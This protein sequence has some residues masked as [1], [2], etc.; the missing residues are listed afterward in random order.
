MI[1]DK[2][3]ICE[4][5]QIDKSAIDNWRNINYSYNHKETNHQEIDFKMK[6]FFKEYWI[7]IAVSMGITILMH[8]LLDW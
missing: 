6:K 8:V 7:T 5:S 1:N 4:Y 2:T 3:A